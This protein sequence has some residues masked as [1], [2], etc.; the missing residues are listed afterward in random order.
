MVKNNGNTT[1]LGTNKTLDE[2]LVAIG[3]WFAV[4]TIDKKNYLWCLER[5]FEHW[6][7]K[8]TTKSGRFRP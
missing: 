1:P 7:W 5:A 4:G 6:G 2:R 3:I 8:S